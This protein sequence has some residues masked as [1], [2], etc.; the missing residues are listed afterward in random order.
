MKKFKKIITIFCLLI[1]YCYFINI[2]NFPNSIITYNENL[3]SYKLCPFLNLKGET[4]V[5]YTGNTSNYKLSLALGN[6]DIKDI[7]LTVLEKTYLVPIGKT[8][9]IKLYIDGVMIVGFSEIENIDGKLE[10]IADTSNLEEGDRII[11]IND[12]DIYNIE[13]LRN[14]INAMNGESLKVQVENINGE[15]KEETITPIKTGENEYKIGLWVKEGATGVGTISFYNPETMEF[16][17]LGHG[18]VD[19]DTGELLT[20]EKGE[21]TETE[22]ISVT[23][24]VSRKSRRS[25]RNNK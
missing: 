8:A 13:D 17:A 7:D 9:G 6:V 18:I 12:K 1:L 20:I 2:S 23:K 14:E 11:K 25:K 3:S 24:G 21:I 22:I 10:S 16:A 4:L 19:S 5:S 15:I